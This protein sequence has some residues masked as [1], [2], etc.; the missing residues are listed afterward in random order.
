M[1]GPTASDYQNAFEQERVNEYPVMDELE[2]AYGYTLDRVRLERAASVLACPVK[3]NPPN[4]QHGRLL[5]AVA[6]QLFEFKRDSYFF[7]DVG[8]AKGFS[9]LCMQWAINDAGVNAKVVS[10]DVIDPTTVV[11]RNTISDL[12]GPRDLW[13]ILAPWPE[14]KAIEFVQSTGVG[15]I[16][17]CTHRINFAFLDGKHRYDDVAMEAQLLIKRQ[18]QGDHIVFDDLQ[19]PGVEKAVDKLRGYDVHKV[20]IKPERRYAIAVKR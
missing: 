3:V 20:T 7:L 11:K 9:A 19:I 15:Y 8:T 5:Y 17:G 6:R 12:F 10:V 16:L 14:A 1:S 4:W 18:E 13:Q 2:E